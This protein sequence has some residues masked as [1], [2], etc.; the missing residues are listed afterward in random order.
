M[1]SFWALSQY[2]GAQLHHNGFCDV[3]IVVICV[4]FLILSNL[5]RN[6]KI[7][8]YLCCFV[9][10]FQGTPASRVRYK[11]DVVQFPYSAS[12]FDVEESSGRVVTRVNLNEEP[13]TVF[14]VC[15]PMAVYCR[16]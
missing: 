15:T 12:I 11:V 4:A 2:K 3:T 8:V 10:A 13:S 14:K 5:R 9:S 16:R 6:A 1:T 7:K